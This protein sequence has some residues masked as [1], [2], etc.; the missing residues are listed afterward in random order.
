M[1]IVHGAC[2]TVLGLTGLLSVWGQPCAGAVLDPCLSLAARAQTN[3][4]AQLTLNGESAVTYLIQTS[5]D[6][7]HWTPVASN[8]D[9]AITRVFNLPSREGVTFYRASRAPL[10]LFAYAIAS[11]YNLKLNGTSLLTDSYNSALPT[12][13]TN[14]LY[15]PAKTRTN[16]HVASLFGPVALGQ[17]LIEGDLYLGPTVTTSLSGGQISGTIHTDFNTCFPDVVLPTTTWVTATKTTV[18]GAQLY[19]FKAS[20]YYMVADS[21]DVRVEPGAVVSLKVVSASYLPASIRVLAT[22]GVSGTLS[23]YQPAGTAVLN[24][25]I[26]DSGRPRN[27]AYYGAA[28]VAN[29][30]VL[31][32]NFTGIIYAP[33]ADLTVNGGALNTSYAGSCIAKS[34]TMNGSSMMFH[35]DED[36]LLAGPT[37]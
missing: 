37:R 9:A 21:S 32:T 7:Q 27:F 28:G 1:R 12:L 14:G 4:Q 6:L 10:P 31:E 13:S 36:L 19:D 16:G 25:V 23:I 34:L 26:V 17:H 15:D 2:A 33:S 30:V 22:N 8:H 24:S 29:V 20:G 11:R 3:G 5:S 18:N 35:F